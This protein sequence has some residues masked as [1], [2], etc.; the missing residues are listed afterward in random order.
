MSRPCLLLT[1]GALVA[2]V[3][4]EGAVPAVDASAPVSAHT[5][6]VSLRLDVSPVQPATL[7]VLAFRA[8]FSGVAVADVLGMVDPL[9]NEA[10]RHDCQLR[11][12]D[13]AA[14]ALVARGDAIELEELAGIGVSVS[15]TGAPEIRPS[16]R[17]YPD[18][19]ATIGGV[20]GEA[21]PLHL[22]NV[23][24][25]VRVRGGMTVVS[26]AQSPEGNEAADIATVT[27]PATGW[28]KLL[29]GA[30]PR[31]GI[32]IPMGNDLNLNLTPFD[33]TDT[34]IELRP[35]GGTV[36]LS[37]AVPASTLVGGGGS[38]DGAG[39]SA[40]HVAF[41]IPR[42]TLGALV[43]ATGGAPGASVAAALDLVRRSNKT[44]P[45]SGTRVSLEVRTSTFVEL[46]P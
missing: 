23:P 31:D 42:Q 38:G 40:T 18:L 9:A 14:A 21:G 17:L 41:M 1:V 26:P 45:L 3:G 7:T 22:L 4:C 25:Q 8:A 27:V 37:C 2:A 46:R 34:S 11:D 20:V 36:A 6:A 35:Y 16:P 28:V 39:G 44:L 19:A 43:A 10:P 13:Q 12:L 30:V 33:A 32:L 29:N 5:S 24:E 15:A